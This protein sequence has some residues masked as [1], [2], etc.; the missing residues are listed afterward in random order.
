MAKQQF[1]LYAATASGL[2]ALAGQELRDLGYKVRVDNGRIYFE[3]DMTDILRANIWLRS[4]DRIKI[5]LKT[6][7]ATT[8]DDIF[9]TVT[10]MDWDQ[11]L[12]MDA[13]FPVNG[14]SKKIPNFLVSPIFKR[15]LKRRSLIKW[16]VLSPQEPLP[17]N[18]RAILTRNCAE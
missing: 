5:I 2:E 7:K 10:A 12:P 8:F 16:P 1:Q 3:G 17:R 13:K 9:D 14:R 18:G 4:A 11:L 15:S 6:F